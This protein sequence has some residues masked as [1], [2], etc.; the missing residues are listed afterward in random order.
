MSDLL[1][2]A[3]TGHRPEK[4]PCGNDEQHPACLSI[5][6]AILRQIERLY[7][8]RGV[9]HFIT[10]GA[11]GVDQWAAEAVIAF[12][13][14]HPDVSLTIAV[15][16]RG[17]ADKFTPEQ[18]KQYERTLHKANS[19]IVLQEQY[20]SN[21]FFKRNDYMVEHAS[22]LVAVYDRSSQV[23]SGTGYTVNKAVSKQRNIIF[24]DPKTQAISAPGNHELNDF[25]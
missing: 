19:V 21:C 20:S 18:K 25:V 1:S 9:K 23:R 14:A 3:F 17:Q 5:K 8:Q 16:F 4:L 2:C 24:I 11:I 15:P 13:E 7:D 12:R 6:A 10:G 22:I